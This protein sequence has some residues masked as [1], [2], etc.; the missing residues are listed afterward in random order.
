MCGAQ[1]CPKSEVNTQND[2]SLKLKLP[3]WGLKS[4][5]TF[6]VIC[7]LQMDNPSTPA[8]AKIL[9]QNSANIF[10][11]KSPVDC[12]RELFKTL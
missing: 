3:I 6:N 8:C 5:F 12:D 1:N 9:A 4:K 2:G 10:H 11:Y 7:L